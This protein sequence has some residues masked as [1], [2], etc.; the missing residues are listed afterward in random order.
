MPLERFVGQQRTERV[1]LRTYPSLWQ[2]YRAMLR[3]LKDYEQD[4]SMSVVV[5]DVA[6]LGPA[7]AGEALAALDAFESAMRPTGLGQ[8]RPYRGEKR[9]GKQFE[10]ALMPG[11]VERLDAL[12]ETIEDARGED[13]RPSRA[14]LV[15]A[16]LHFGPASEED[17]L[18]QRGRVREGLRAARASA[19]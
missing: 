8:D 6:L 7:D 2:R 1:L 18:R 11:V 13:D 10:V 17:L 16:L 5:N 14:R 3:T 4:L 19:S 9:T 15:T 12:I